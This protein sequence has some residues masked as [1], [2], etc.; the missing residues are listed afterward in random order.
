MWLSQWVND[1]H[2][3]AQKYWKATFIIWIIYKYSEDQSTT[4]PQQG[5]TTTGRLMEQ[6]TPHLVSLCMLLIAMRS[7]FDMKVTLDM[8][9]S[10]IMRSVLIWGHFWYGDQ[11]WSINDDWLE[12]SCKTRE[13]ASWASSSALSHQKANSTNAGHFLWA[14]T[15]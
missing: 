2:S 14:K 13:P 5:S 6:L 12:L 7:V 8:M 10:F 15:L 11:F 9:V 1:A 3:K 4:S